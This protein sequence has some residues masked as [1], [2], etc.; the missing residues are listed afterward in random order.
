MVTARALPTTDDIVGWLVRWLAQSLSVAA[1]EID[2][3]EPFATY[4]LTSLN[5]VEMSGDLER[6]L[7]AR[8]PPDLAWNY[9]C[10][11]SLAAHLAAHIRTR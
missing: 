4:G 2:I 3:R 11:E 5:A 1:S 8:L 6:W 10:V 9:P 7:G